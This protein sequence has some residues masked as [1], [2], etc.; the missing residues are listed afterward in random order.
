MGLKVLAEG[1]IMEEEETLGVPI[2]Q[3]SEYMIKASAEILKDDANNAFKQILE[4]S[5]KFKEAGL[6]PIYLYDTQNM[7]ISLIVLETFGKKLH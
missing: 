4:A 2:V 1:R 5:D 7:H 6:T 3:V